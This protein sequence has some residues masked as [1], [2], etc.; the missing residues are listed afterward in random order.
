MAG[1]IVVGG[2]LAGLTCAWRLRRAGHDVEVLEVGSGVGGRARAER[3]GDFRIQRGASFVTSGQMNVRS[4]ATALGLANDIVSLGRREE[5]VPA[6]VLRD[7]RLEACDLGSALGVARS[8]LLSPI[9]KL[10]LGRLA[11]EVV[12]HRAR[13]DPL[14]PARAARLE[15]G[16]PLS[17]FVARTVGSAAHDRLVAPLVSFLL[18]CAPEEVSPAFLL[19]TLRSLHQGAAP[20]TLAGGLG[21][22]ADALA[23]AVPIRTGCEVFSI[24]TESGG[25]R[26]GYHGA[27][28]ERSAVADGVVV[29]VPANVVPLLCPKLTPDEQGFFAGLGHASAI[30]VGLMLDEMPSAFG[31]FGLA[32]ATGERVGLRALLQSHR[33]PGA[34]PDGCGLLTAVL[35]D[36]AV[37]RLAQATDKEIGAFAEEAVAGLPIGRV[38]VRAT[39]VSRWEYA[40]PTFSRGALSRLEHFG[41]R[42][43]RSPRLAFAGDY[44]IG[45]TVEGAVTSGMR[46]AS[47][48]IQSLDETRSEAGTPAVSLP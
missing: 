32:V 20:L 14:R 21:R 40:R 13:L 31:A 7:G 29:A 15:H 1:I 11:A 33:E 26:V 25:A 19:L 18:G 35:A 39:A 8:R 4:V 27:G 36:G 30:Q 48:V 24:E 22:L 3:D 5:P 45:P 16:E 43:D 44:L 46:A 37:R 38:R 47:R 28:R 6:L 10:R 9:S 41:V 12:R 2:G 34:A 17:H 23:D 42:M